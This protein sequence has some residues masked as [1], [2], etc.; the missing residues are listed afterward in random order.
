MYITGT[1]EAVNWRYIDATGI[2]VPEIVLTDGTVIGANDR[3]QLPEHG[4]EITVTVRE[5]KNG[6]LRYKSGLPSV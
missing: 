1:V 4:D 5:A 6:R 3:V 2:D